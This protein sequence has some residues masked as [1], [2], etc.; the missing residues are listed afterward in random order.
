[1]TPLWPRDANRR[2]A[3]AKPSLRVRR[4]I[5]AAIAGPNIPIA[6]RMVN[7]TPKAA[8]PS[9]ITQ[10]IPKASAMNN[11]MPVQ[12][13]GAFSGCKATGSGVV[14]W[15]SMGNSLFGKFNISVLIEILTYFQMGCQGQTFPS[16]FQGKQPRHIIELHLVL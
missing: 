4:T 14:V 13:I 8:R 7:E 3:S 16:T 15:V 6:T 5:V 11:A 1:M 10:L 2:P 9:Q 12:S